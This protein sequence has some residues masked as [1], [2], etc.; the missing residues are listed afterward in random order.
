MSLVQVLY[1]P[2][3]VPVGGPSAAPALR[4]RVPQCL[5]RQVALASAQVTPTS[6]VLP[7]VPL[8]SYLAAGLVFMLIGGRALLLYSSLCCPAFSLPCF[9][10]WN[11]LCVIE[12]RKASCQLPK[13]LFSWATSRRPS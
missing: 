4:P 11:R 2:D 9:K 5:H 3:G 10:N 12:A 13:S 7:A 8:R 6:V 1:L